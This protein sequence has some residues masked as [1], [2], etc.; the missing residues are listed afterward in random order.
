[1]NDPDWYCE[2]CGQ[3]NWASRSHCRVCTAPKSLEQPTT[4]RTAYSYK[5]TN[6][7]HIRKGSCWNCGST[8]HLKVQCP[9]IDAKS[10]PTIC[11]CKYQKGSC[12]KEAVGCRFLGLPVS[13]CSEY[14]NGRCSKP[15][16]KYTHLQPPACPHVFQKGNCTFGKSCVLA[17]RPCDECSFGA[18]TKG[19]TCPRRH[20]FHTVTEENGVL[21]YTH[22]T[23]NALLPKE[24]GMQF[25][26]NNSTQITVTFGVKNWAAK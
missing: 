13:T 23:K 17:D 2:Q 3:A 8:E 11:P 22:P 19:D 24:P 14:L 18:C 7:E 25:P 20:T 10:A 5:G 9:Y 26:H 6:V 12:E 4:M 15:D 1:M 21:V 16:C